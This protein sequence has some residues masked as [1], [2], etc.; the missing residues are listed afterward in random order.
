MKLCAICGQPIP[1]RRFQADTVRTCSPGCAQTL[2]VK[3]HP[4]IV[5]HWG[6]MPAEPPREDDEPK[7][8]G[9]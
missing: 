7:G 6:R 5:K 8:D 4:D 3:E 9:T 2:A 1:V